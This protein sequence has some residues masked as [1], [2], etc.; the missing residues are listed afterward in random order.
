MVVVVVSELCCSPIS[1]HC[2]GH[3]EVIGLYAASGLFGADR[4]IAQSN[5]TTLDPMTNEYY[6][7]TET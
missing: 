1:W 2:D 4:I 6:W 3:V 5:R 7:R